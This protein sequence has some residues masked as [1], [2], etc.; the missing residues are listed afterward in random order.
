MAELR[1]TM[2]TNF[3]GRN[4]MVKKRNWQ[5]RWTKVVQHWILRRTMCQTLLSFR[6]FW[7]FDF[8]LCRLP[9][10]WKNRIFKSVRMILFDIWFDAEFNAEQL[11]FSDFADFSFLPWDLAPGSVCTLWGVTLLYRL[12]QGI[13]IH[14]WEGLVMAVPLI[15]RWF[16]Y[17][18]KWRRYGRWK[19]LLTTKTRPVGLWAAGD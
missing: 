3:Q 14:R 8:F 4:L 16:S 5:S 10:P 13:I 11:L 18:Q 9:K 2:C 17:L 15:C 1:P 7:K 19:F 6:H 12:F